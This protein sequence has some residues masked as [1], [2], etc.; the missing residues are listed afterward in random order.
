MQR[1]RKY[2]LNLSAVWRASATSD[3]ECP[4]DAKGNIR[5]VDKNKGTVQVV[6][7]CSFSY[8]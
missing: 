8:I 5:F 6:L 3:Y 4:V 7:N 2:C 1:S